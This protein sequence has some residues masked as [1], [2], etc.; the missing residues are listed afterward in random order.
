MDGELRG[1]LVR[2]RVTKPSLHK[3]HRLAQVVLRP[4]TAVNS[5]INILVKDPP[6]S[7]KI[8][9]RDHC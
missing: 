5:F 2:L 1:G 8:R 9:G 6:S 3:K 7:V 4:Y